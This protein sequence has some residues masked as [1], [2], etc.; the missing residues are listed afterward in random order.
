MLQVARDLHERRE[1]GPARAALAQ[2]ATLWP[3]SAEADK[4][5]LLLAAGA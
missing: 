5:R 2:V 1:N 4:A 3:G